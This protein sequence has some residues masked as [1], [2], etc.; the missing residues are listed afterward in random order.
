MLTP[1]S[2]MPFA[3]LPEMMLRWLALVPPIWRVKA[4]FE[5]IPIPFGLRDQPDPINPD[6]VAFDDRTLS[7][8]NHLDRQLPRIR[9]WRNHEWSHPRR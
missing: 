4:E 1:V 6:V 2:E 3:E 7:S 9:R 8:S 5:L